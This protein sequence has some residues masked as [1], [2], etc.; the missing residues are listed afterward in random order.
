MNMA[1]MASTV[2]GLPKVVIGHYFLEH[3]NSDYSNATNIEV[4]LSSDQ[5]EYPLPTVC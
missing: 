4:S 1:Q 3:P 5:I 2:T